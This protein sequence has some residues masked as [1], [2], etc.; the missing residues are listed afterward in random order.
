MLEAHER[1]A[2]V[3]PDRMTTKRAIGAV[4]VEDILKT[5]R[6]GRGM[7]Q[8]DAATYLGVPKRTLQD[9]EQGR[10]KPSAVVSKIAERFPT[11]VS[12]CQ[13]RLGSSIE[14]RILYAAIVDEFGWS[15]SRADWLKAL[16]VLREQGVIHF[17]SAEDGKKTTLRRL[18]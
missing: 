9:W 18:L 8:R 1:M 10:R 14:N 7:S 16:K 3:A 4:A 11:I 5:W 2:K 12:R 13:W 15:A 17:E 6:K